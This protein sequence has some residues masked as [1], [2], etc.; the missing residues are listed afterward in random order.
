MLPRAE[1]PQPRRCG[2]D[3][4]AYPVTSPPPDNW[5][6]YK[7]GDDAEDFWPTEQAKVAPAVQTGLLNLDLRA[8]SQGYVIANSAPPVSLAD[9]IAQQLV[10]HSP[11]GA[12][13]FSPV[14]T[15]AELAQALASDWEN[16]FKNAPLP[17]GANR[18]DLLPPFTA[19]G[20]PDAQIAAFVRYVRKFFDLPT[21]LTPA[22]SGPSGAPPTLP[23][24]IVDPIQSF[25]VAYE[26]LIGGVFTFGTPLVA[27]TV[28]QA[29]ANVFPSDPQAQ[30]WL[31]DTIKALNDLCALASVPGGVNPLKPDLQFSVAEA[32]YAR[33]ITSVADVLALSQSDF[34]DALRGTIAYDQAAAIYA[35]ALT[36]GPP[37]PA[38]TGPGG[39][40]NPVNPGTL[41]NC[42]PPCH[43]S[44]L[45]AVEYLHELLQLSENSTR[46]DPYSA[47]TAGHLT[48]GD[49]LAARRGPLGNLHATRANEGV[50]LPLI[51][52]VNE[53]LEAMCATTPPTAHGV[54]YDTAEDTLAGLKLC[55]DEG[56]CGEREH[57]G[58][59]V[60]CHDPTVLFAALPEHS[61]PAG[62]TAANASVEPAAFNVLKSDFSSC[63]LPYSQP[64]DVDRTYLR[65]F[66]TS[67]FE[68]MRTFR[69][70]ITEFVLA[71]EQEPSGFQDHLWR[72]PV[73]IDIA[74]EY[75]CITPEEYVQVFGGHWPANCGEARQEEPPVV[76]NEGRD[77]VLQSH[78]FSP[79]GLREDAASRMGIRLPQ[80][81][82]LTCLTY[83]EF[84]ELWK[85]KFVLFTN[86]ADHRTGAFP[87]CE[88]CCLDD[89]QILFPEEAN[90]QQALY[91]L[92]VFIRLW[93]KLKALVGRDILSKNLEPICSVLELF[94][95]GTVNPDFIRQLAAFQMLRDVFAL[96]LV[97]RD[98]PPAPGAT[99]ANRLHILA[100][101]V[102][103][104][105]AKWEWAVRQLLHGVQ[106]RAQHRYRCA[107]LPEVIK[108][109]Y[110][111]L[112]PLS[113][114]AGFDLTSATETWHALPTHT[115]RFAEILAKIAASNFGVGEI[116]FLFTADPHV[117]G[118]DPFALQGLNEGLDTP[119]GLPDGEHEFS[120]WRL[121]HKLLETNVADEDL[122]EW[123]WQRIVHALQQFGFAH[124]D[125]TS[126]G[127]HFFP[128][129]MAKSGYTVPPANRGYTTA[130]AA[131]DTAPRMWNTPPEGPFNYD[132]ATE[133][134]WTELPLLDHEVI[135]QF[136]HL[137]PLTP[138]EQQAV[139]D[140]YF[141]PRRTLA[142]FAM[143]FADFAEAERRL[144]EERE[145]ERW[146]WF[147]RQFAQFHRRCH[148]IAEHL[149]EHV[150]TATGQKHPVGVHTAFLLLQSLSA[151]ENFATSSWEDDGGH[152]PA[153]TWTAP[154]GGAF[155]ALLGLTG[156]GLLAEYA[157]LGGPLVWRDLSGPTTAFSPERNA[158]NCPVPTIVPSLHATVPM[159][160]QQFVTILNGMVM[161]NG[162][163]A[164]LG[165]A[166]AFTVK[167]TGALAVEDPG[168]YEFCAGG[169]TPEGEPPNIDD[170]EHQRWR[171]IL[172][173]GQQTW[174]LLKHGWGAE[175][176]EAV[177]AVPLKRGVYEVRIEFTQN[178]PTILR[179]EDARRLRTG[180]Q[181][182]YT[183][184]DTDGRLMALPHHRLFRLSKDAT[185]SHGLGDLTG[186]PASYLQERYTSSLRDI[187]RTYQRG[188]KALLFAHRF[189]LSTDHWTDRRSELGY[190]LAQ[191]SLFAGRA[192][193]RSGAAFSPHAAD[194]DFNLLPLLDDYYAPAAATDA[195][196]QP[197]LQR[198]QA[199]FDWW[200]RI[201]D[202]TKVREEVER[203]CDRRLWRLFDEAEEKRPAHPGYLLRHMG[204]DARHW[205][206]DLHYFQ[207][208]AA[209]VYA[210]TADD[211]QDDRWV[212]RAWHADEWIKRLLRAFC[213]K[214][215]RTARPDLW[216][217]DD[218][219]AV[220]PG[221]GPDN[222]PNP[223]GLANLSQFLI[224]GCLEN[225][226]PKRYE[227]LKRLNDCLRERGRD[228]LLAYLC[229]M[230]RTPLPWGGFAKSPKD[231][232]SL[233]LIDVEA[234]IPECAS[235]IE[236]AVTAAQSFVRRARLGLEPGWTVNYAF[237]E[238]WDRHF[239]NFKVW[240]AC[241]CRELYKENWI[242]W[243]AQAAAQKVESFQFLQSEL[244]RSTLTAA[245][246]GGLE[247]WPDQRPPG[248]PSLLLLQDRDP[249]T[250]TQLNP[251]RE[252]LGLL[253]APER[254]ARPSWLA[255]L[256]PSLPSGGG[257]G[258]GVIERARDVRAAPAPVPVAES[259]TLPFWIEAAI[260]LGV[261]FYRVAA[262]GVPPAS[263]HFEAREYHAKPGCCTE[264]GKVHPEQ[265]D[266]YYFWLLDF[267]LLQ[268][269]RR[270]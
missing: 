206:T 22:A 108:L 270:D 39:P 264:C 139:Q 186:V 245:L 233:L 60:K 69:R 170:C 191:K 32:L 187:R 26:A 128:D 137:R 103:P 203:D 91:E 202:Y 237:A 179:D 126:F 71:P 55:V 262:G 257:D 94:S 214:D 231:L 241:K 266:E 68:T 226:T 130:L 86:G 154:R 157:R 161:R 189:R 211:L 92:I 62:P 136:A 235:R 49:A 204:A 258:G 65:H 84:L 236:E 176:G 7:P 74:I 56:C 23:T 210:L 21:S 57:E 240:E 48:L 152:A 151:D 166:E 217:A 80:F 222:Q 169:P 267:P 42:I 141:S 131:A 160:Q 36:L 167:W 125:V 244:R 121:R 10:V 208:Q 30:Q 83:C 250:L 173:R 105:A 2:R 51:D 138:N 251:P 53:S 165:G 37:M 247:Y 239:T 1:S 269:G 102:A 54:V 61:T 246:P 52:I 35:K 98:D 122:S 199:L 8:L 150:R 111:N 163:D 201:F 207:S 104:G 212:V 232:S 129:L 40:F 115:L 67:R 100:L 185:L 85:S 253:G 188:F 59:V 116:L 220:V 197:S 192:F 182:K 153:T 101:W 254:G 159:D 172:K 77:A 14:T 209:S 18:N 268:G 25:V 47:P 113:R 229:A 95:G 216:A 6:S 265:V 181:L 134:L 148:V 171:V 97:D 76:G 78:G 249:S 227:D 242:D 162:D 133:T 107:L 174:L 13:L 190:M 29:V 263:A 255:P 118:D 127:E 140:L 81:L 234:G 221:L 156:T 120:L 142:A 193:Y 88:P 144:I 17:P 73:R 64:L 79:V 43:L 180:F 175:G 230:D 31:K 5:L 24:P 99:G 33:G 90:V 215:I 46:E 112:D 164:W 45:G 194:F 168:T 117:D 89:L 12:V 93:R 9:F 218:P 219:S 124:S 256:S 96:R 260:R 106:H 228:A 135:K 19:P 15:I 223:T 243:N 63:C 225:D 72:Y 177:P 16:L 110:D 50:S 4:K 66:C 75:L 114:F 261:R 183:G 109:L 238:L 82:E 196:V 11:A 248:H 158:H 132:L 147:Q 205:S 123:T 224:T 87:E 38:P 119:L 184:P 146:S 27:A 259:G 178:R 70:C 41:T 34:Q 200:E 155:A 145:H 149:S 28:D 3:F 195:R 44:P 252:G 198:R 58:Q 213:A 143:I 20:T